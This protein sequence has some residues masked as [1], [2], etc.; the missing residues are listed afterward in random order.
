MSILCD[1]SGDGEKLSLGNRNNATL[2]NYIVDSAG[3]DTGMG[4]DLA[5]QTV[6]ESATLGL[7]MLD[8]LAISRRKNMG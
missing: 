6:P 4:F 5:F 8:G 2:P 7:L 1:L 3:G